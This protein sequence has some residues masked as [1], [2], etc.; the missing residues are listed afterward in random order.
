MVLAGIGAGVTVT[1]SAV[2]ILACGFFPPACAACPFVA[3][4]A[5]G[6]VIDEI[7]SI[8]ADSLESEDDVGF[9][10]FVDMTST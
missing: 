5:G 9:G 2:C 8:D 1:V 6:I 7:A 3:V 10:P 4:G